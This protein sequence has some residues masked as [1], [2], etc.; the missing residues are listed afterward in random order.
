LSIQSGNT[1]TEIA[2]R[3]FHAPVD[4][5]IFDH[6]PAFMIAIWFSFSAG[7]AHNLVACLEQHGR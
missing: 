4:S 5:Q 6:A 1:I 2:R 7:D 3:F